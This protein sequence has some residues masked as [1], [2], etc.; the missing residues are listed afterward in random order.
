VSVLKILLNVN[1]CDAAIRKK[2]VIKHVLGR[3]ASNAYKDMIQNFNVHGL[4]HRD[5]LFFSALWT[6]LYILKSLVA[7]SQRCFSALIHAT[8]PSP[9]IA[10]GARPGNSEVSQV[11]N[12]EMIS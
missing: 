7:S 11:V 4:Y 2:E 8:F 10:A 3:V 1:S 5:K 9:S 6:V 12:R